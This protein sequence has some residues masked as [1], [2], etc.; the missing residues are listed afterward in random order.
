[1]SNII[2]FICVTIEY[3]SFYIQ[4][5]YFLLELQFALTQLY[6][7]NPYFPEEISQIQETFVESL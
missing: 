4:G 3:K 7:A 6:R 1:M 5:H 2:H